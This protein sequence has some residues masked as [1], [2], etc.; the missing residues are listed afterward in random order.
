MSEKKIRN[1]FLEK[2]APRNVA[3]W[4]TTGSMTLQSL[5]LCDSVGTALLSGR[6][7]IGV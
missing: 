3:Y 5:Q 4:A 1:P 6:L 7:T 2:R